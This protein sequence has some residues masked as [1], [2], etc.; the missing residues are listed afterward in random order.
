MSSLAPSEAPPRPPSMAHK[1]WPEQGAPVLACHGVVRELGQCSVRLG[2]R[3]EQRHPG[4]REKELARKPGH[5][6][7]GLK[8]AE[9][10]A[11]DPRERDGEHADVQAAETADE[12]REG[13][14][15]DGDEGEIHE[16]VARRFCTNSAACHARTPVK[17]AIC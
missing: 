1:P 16:R 12:H 11:D 13:E 2:H 6:G 10:H 3:E 14:R 8:A 9:V 4:E 15:T 17:S 7:V 5:H